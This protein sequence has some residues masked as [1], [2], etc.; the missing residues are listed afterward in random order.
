[1]NYYA[2]AIIQAMEKWRTYWWLLPYIGG[3]FHISVVASI[4]MWLLPYNCG[5]Q[6]NFRPRGYIHQRLRNK[7]RRYFSAVFR[8]DTFRMHQRRD[9][10]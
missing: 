10:L 7:I 3:C 1:M 6:Q 9:P 5:C 8:C 2:A 4:Y